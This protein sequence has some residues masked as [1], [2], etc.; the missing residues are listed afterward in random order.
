MDHSAPRS[1]K[2]DTI[3]SLRTRSKIYKDSIS[4]TALLKIGDEAVAALQSQSQLAMNELLLCDE[5][6]R[7][8][9]KRQKLPS[10][11]TWR[12]MELKRQKEREE[13]RRPEHWGVRPDSMLAREVQP[14]RRLSS[15]GRGTFVMRARRSVSRGA[16]L[17][18]D[19][20]HAVG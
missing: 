6:D 9:R 5:V 8:I 1:L 2:H 16:G 12:R 18:S 11:S 19:R 10:Y 15:T 13:F 17:F 20:D 7:I 4:R 14:S 3:C